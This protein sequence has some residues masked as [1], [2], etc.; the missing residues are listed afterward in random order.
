MQ[1]NKEQIFGYMLGL[2]DSGDD[3]VVRKV[4]EYFGKSKSTVYNYF[5]EL[6]REGKICKADGKYRLCNREYNFSYKNN[7]KLS[8]SRICSSDFDPLISAFPKNVISIWRYAFMEMM[9][10]AIEHS[11][12]DEISVKVIATDVKT[13]V[14][15]EDNGIGIFRN[16]REYLYKVNGED[17]PIDEC[18]SLLFAGKFTTAKD[19]HSG[20]GIFFTSHMMDEFMIISDGTLFTRDNFRDGRTNIEKGSSGTL[21]VMSLYNN[22]KKTA[23]EI[24]DRFSNVD[25]GFIKTSIPIAH[26]FPGGDPIS[27]SEARRLGEMILSFKAVEMDFSGVE[28]IGQAFTHELFVLWKAKNPHIELIVK[29][30]CENVDF[31]IRR[32]VN[33]K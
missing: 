14:Y 28:E 23:R 6:Q 32:V 3:D 17:I 10:N 13:T 19:M 1:S 8:E 4:V 22:T 31:M 7:G 12:A 27:R 33:T 5:N 18:I 24:F 30:A 26:F 2:I 11:Q 15:I 20:E 25:E 21:V 9:N 29:N 16:I